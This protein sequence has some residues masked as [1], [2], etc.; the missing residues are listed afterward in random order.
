VQ[1]LQPSWRKWS[2]TIALIG[3]D[4]TWDTSFSG[5]YL[6]VIYRNFSFQESQEQQKGDKMQ[7]EADKMF[8]ERMSGSGFWMCLH[9]AL[10][11]QPRSTQ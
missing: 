11:G 7:K 10:A 1:A 6:L 5:C 2:E 9:S 8:I 4:S 3:I